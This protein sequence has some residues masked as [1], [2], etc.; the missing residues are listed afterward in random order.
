[1]QL[2]VPRLLRRRF[3]KLIWSHAPRRFPRSDK[4]LAIVIP[5]AVKDLVKAQRCVEAL[6]R[7]VL[8]PIREIVVPGQNHPDIAAFCARLGLRY[9]DENDVLPREVL[10]LAYTPGGLKMNG[11]IRQQMLKLSAWR[12]V[13]GDNFLVFDADTFLMRD[14]SFL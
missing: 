12:Y 8:H 1:M 3:H 11:H 5:L 2:T 6:R 14:L 9:V 10:E 13:E 4:P 7:H